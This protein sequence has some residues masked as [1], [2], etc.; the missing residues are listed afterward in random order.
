MYLHF[1]PFFPILQVFFCLFFA[2]FMHLNSRTVFFWSLVFLCLATIAGITLYSFGY[3]YRFDRGIF[4]YTGSVSLKVNP[5]DNLTI[6]L[7]G[8]PVNVKASTINGSFHLT[9]IRPGLHH[10][11][12][13]ADGFQAWE[14]EV[15]VSSGVSTDFWNI[16]LIRNNYPETTIVSHPNIDK[17]YPSPDQKR[18]AYSVQDDDEASVH[19]F[20]L[21]TGEDTRVF[22][23]NDRFFASD[24][25]ENIEWS[26]KGDAITIPLFSSSAVDSQREYFIISLSDPT[27][28]F[29]ATN[30][31]DIADFTDARDLRWTLQT[32]EALIFLDGTTL[33]SVSFQEPRI[34][35][36]LA[37]NVSSYELSGS[38]L[39]TFESPNFLVW[40]AP[41][42]HPENRTQITVQA[43]H[44]THDG[45]SF[46]LIVYDASRLILLDHSAKTLTLFNN[47]PTQPVFVTL[48]QPIT[49][50]Q[51]SND[52]KKLLYWN[53]LEVGVYFL[54][55][56][57][58]Q[59]TRHENQ[60]YE[61]TRFSQPIRFVQ[62]ARDYEHILLATPLGMETIELDNRSRLSQKVTF[63]SVD[64]IRQ[65]TP[66]AAQSRLFLLQAHQNEGSTTTTLSSI[67]FPEPIL[68][69]G[70]IQ[71]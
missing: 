43:P 59:P 31:K 11:R 67:I 49:G 36:S 69:F 42:D 63:D 24:D 8:N 33:K 35:R 61:I 54:R 27:Q 46:S 23:R 32:S 38:T 53:E 7:D 45:D 37:E 71:Q 4:V 30:L 25:T 62:W 70:I 52:G 50:A 1:S 64:P 41:L 14:K 5:T 57:E 28:G 39:Y 56:W 47:S 68:R 20:D 12:V 16:L 65:I 3:R 26:P 34:T 60:S 44:N 29:P 9:G 13:S 19:T 15:P 6:T 48:P 10:I 21:T 18:I 66:A 40:Q 2:I 51:F 58:A 17:F 22:S 55:N